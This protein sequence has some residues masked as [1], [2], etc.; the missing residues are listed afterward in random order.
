MDRAGTA[1]E[2]P[3]VVKKNSDDSLT[4][5]MSSCAIVYGLATLGRI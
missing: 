1:D 3:V 2:P 4:E 5:N